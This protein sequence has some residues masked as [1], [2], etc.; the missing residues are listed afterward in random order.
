MISIDKHISRLIAG[1]DCVIIPGFGAFLSQRIPAHY[2][3]DEQIYMPPRRTLG[4][5]PQITMED[6]LLTTAYMQQYGISYNQA[7]ILM[8]DDVKKLKKR[9][10]RKGQLYFGELGVLSMNIEGTISF[11]PAENC[12]DDPD[13]YGMIPLPI[14]MLSHKEEPT[15]TIKINRHRVSQYIA[16]AAAIIIMFIFVTPLS[17]HTFKNDTKASLGN[18][19]SPEQISMMQQVSAPAPAAVT[20]STCEICPIEESVKQET[21]TTTAATTEVV[22]TPT[23]SQSDNQPEIAPATKYHII[24]ASSPTE[25]NADL[26]IKEL[27]SKAQ[28]G[29][30]KV[31]SN[32]RFRISAGS[33]DTQAEAQSSLSSIQATFPDAWIF[34]HQ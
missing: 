9:L 17:E 1:H 25:T 33:Y 29:Y 6:A 15:I 10:S 22:E 32:G 21:A 16:A 4:F 13:N 27:T 30:T 34:K 12:I 3:A 2:N 7:A 8:K 5:N 26:A 11:E 20:K 24:V 14:P 19:A 31:K 28:F 18:F 23:E